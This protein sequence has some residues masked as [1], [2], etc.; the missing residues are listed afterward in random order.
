MRL[1]FSWV[2]VVG[3]GVSAGAQTYQYPFRNPNLPTEERITDLLSR[4]TLEEKI[5]SLGTDPDVPRL[6]VVGTDHT[7][8]LHG[9]ALDG[10]AGWDGR[11]RATITPT[12]FPQAR[13]LG[14]WAPPQH[15]LHMM[16][17]CP[18]NPW[19]RST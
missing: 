8:G 5:N 15:R 4:M 7:E 3:I 9:L 19:S 1:R 6:G 14:Q 12:T 16:S 18:P 13:G 10:P 17:S 11:R 2:L